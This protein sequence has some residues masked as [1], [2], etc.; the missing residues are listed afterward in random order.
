MAT[1]PLTDDSDRAL[2]AQKVRKVGKYTALYTVTLLFVAFAALPFA[3]MVFTV[4]HPAETAPS[5]QSGSDV[6]QT[7]ADPIT[8][9]SS[10]FES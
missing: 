10:I 8:R 3:W 7:A 1:T 9:R 6:G 2:R 5:C 4:C